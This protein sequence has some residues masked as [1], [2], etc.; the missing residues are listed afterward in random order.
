[1]RAGG[2]NGRSPARRWVFPPTLSSAGMWPVQGQRRAGVS[3][4]WCCIRVCAPRGYPVTVRSAL[5]GSE[6]QPCSR[7]NGNLGEAVSCSPREGLIQVFAAHSMVGRA[8]AA[9]QGQGEMRPF[10]TETGCSFSNVCF[11]FACFCYCSWCAC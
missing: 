5:F 7:F 9:P 11:A 10:D 1:M 3:W 6:M 2:G 4:H 8:T